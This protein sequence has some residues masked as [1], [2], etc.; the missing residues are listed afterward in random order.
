MKS[1]SII[2]IVVLCC[3]SAQLQLRNCK[4]LY[5]EY[6]VNGGDQVKCG[7]LKTAFNCNEDT[8]NFPTTIDSNYQPKQ[9]GERGG[10]GGNGGPSLFGRG[11][12]GGN[13]K[14]I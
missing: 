3:A 7:L 12:D 14:C 8:I 4:A 6:C 5:N 10:N 1:V 11:G 13:C 9:T 2:V